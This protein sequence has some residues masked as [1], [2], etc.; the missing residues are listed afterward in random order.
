MEKIRAL[1]VDDEILMC[2]ELKSLVEVYQG[3]EV[4]GICQDGAKAIKVIDELHPD[5]VFLDIQ[6]PGRNGLQVAAS[7][8]NRPNAPLVVFA[9]AYDDYALKAFEVNAI[10]Y[11]LKPFDEKDVE[12]VINKVKR[13]FDART[14]VSYPRRFTVERGDRIEIIDN[15]R[16]QLIFAKDRLVFIQTVDGEVYNTRL[17]LQEFENRLDPAKFFRCH[18]N[19]IV[20]MEEVKQLAAWFNRGYLLILKGNKHIEVPVS[21]IYTRKLKEYVDL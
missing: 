12:R 21:R 19:Y 6:M 15:A 20:N 11:L 10:D 1:I 5:L 13:R 9:T 14:K 17:S 8:Y 16:I 4:I 3:I 2:N 18:R 7:L